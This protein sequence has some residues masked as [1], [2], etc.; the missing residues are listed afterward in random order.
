MSFLLTAEE[1]RAA[2]DAIR[3]GQVTPRLYA[4][5]GD[6]VAVAQATRALAPSAV[7]GGRWEDPDAVAETLQSW[8]EESL[9]R[10]GL[11]QAFDRCASPRALA[12]YLERALRNWLIARSRRA[13]GPR[14]LERAAELMATDERFRIVREAAT[15]HSRYWG[16]A[17]WVEPEVY[18]GGDDRLVAAAW[19]AGDFAILRYPSSDR[20]DPVLSTPDLRDFLTGLL[21][22]AGKAI[23]GRQLDAA[24][25]GRFG[26]AYAPGSMALRSADLIVADDDPADAVAIRDAA[27]VAL[28]DLTDRQLT[29]VRRRPQGTL[30]QLAEELGV[31][32]GTV[33]NEYRRALIKIHQ[34]SPSRQLFTQTLETVLEMASG[35][36]QD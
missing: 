15:V 3:A 17:E 5:L 19:A 31:S 20:S 29:I 28:A 36:A 1:F 21:N 30:E 25:R 23:S 4:W 24:L 26:Y 9:L 6:V 2:D 18:G 32:R 33:D 12:R 34:A 22:V 7:P 8:L 13:A 35:A 11:L 27:R 14:L 10:G 16:L